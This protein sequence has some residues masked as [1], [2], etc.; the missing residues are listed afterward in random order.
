M[1]TEKEIEKKANE[2]L[3]LLKGLTFGQG[4]KVLKRALNKL[5]L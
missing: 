3:T 1:K 5:I 4:K 2:I